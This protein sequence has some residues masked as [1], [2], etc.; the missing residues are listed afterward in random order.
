[1]PY[2]HTVNEV[3]VTHIPTGLAVIKA[4]RSRL[5]AERHAMAELEKL[6]AEHTD[7]T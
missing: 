2:P 1:M 3:R 5:A 7:A 6:V 4:H